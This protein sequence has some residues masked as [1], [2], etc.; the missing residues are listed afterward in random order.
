MSGRARHLRDGQ[1]ITNRKTDRRNP[2]RSPAERRQALITEAFAKPDPALVAMVFRLPEWLGAATAPGQHGIG[3]EVLK[4][5]FVRVSG[6][7]ADH[8]WYLARSFLGAIARESRGF[9]VHASIICRAGEHAGK[10]Y[11]CFLTVTRGSVVVSMGL[12]EPRLYEA[13]A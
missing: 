13:A 9:T 10:S 4:S 7:S 1:W 8:C 2:R 11:G 6:N 3:I 5:D 12:I